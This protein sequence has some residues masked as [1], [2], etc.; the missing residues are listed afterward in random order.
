MLA[1]HKPSTDKKSLPTYVFKMAQ[2][3]LT[4]ERTISN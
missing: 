1:K 3:K 2:A 4:K